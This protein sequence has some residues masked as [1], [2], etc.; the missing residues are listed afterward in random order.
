MSE[1]DRK[2]GSDALNNA[3]KNNE[4]FIFVVLPKD[5][6][7]PKA[8]VKFWGDM[9]HGKC[10]PIHTI[11]FY[12]RVCSVWPSTRHC[13]TVCSCEQ[14]EGPE[15]GSILSVLEQCIIEVSSFFLPFHSRLC[16]T[17]AMLDRIN[18]RLRGENFRVQGSTV[19]NR[20]FSGSNPGDRPP[21]LTMIIGT[22]R[23]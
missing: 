9:V 3:L 15:A 14:G 22:K 5:A 6:A 16:L 8:T 4:F 21:P 1:I 23:F 11:T 17:P 7:G 13:H 12:R 20:L 2:A 10:V 19:F 18:A